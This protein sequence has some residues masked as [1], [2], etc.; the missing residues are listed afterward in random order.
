[1]NFEF[2]AG[3]VFFALWQPDVAGGAAAIDPLLPDLGLDADVFL[4]LTFEAA[5][6]SDTEKQVVQEL[7]Q[8][9]SFRP[10]DRARLDSDRVSGP[11]PPDQDMLDARKPALRFA[12]LLAAK[13]VHPPIALGL[14][15]NWG[16]GKTFFMGLMRDRI[17]S[18]AGSGGAY[19]GRVVQIEFNAWH[20]HDTNLWASLAMRIFEGLAID[21]G[22]KKDSDIEAIR[23]ALHQKLRSSEARKTEA[24]VRRTQA[25]NRR[26]TVAKELETKQAERIEL[27]KKSVRL[28]LA[29]AWQVVKTDP[30]FAE[31]RVAAW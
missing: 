15:G 6:A 7:L 25:L 29:A 1:S 18:L 31:L 20:Y 30:V 16:S 2:T 13:D 28:R 5:D 26:A 21:L 10:W 11:I 3:G 9:R 4:R 23:K 12:R 8:M 22:G 24:D 14:F 17:S 19:V 27:E